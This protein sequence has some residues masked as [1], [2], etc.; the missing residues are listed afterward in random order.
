M[1]NAKTT[2]VDSEIAVRPKYYEVY[3][4]EIANGNRAWV[5]AGLMSLVALVSL[6]F[7]II[8]RIQVLVGVYEEM[9]GIDVP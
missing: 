9:V 1:E 2:E 4:A 7:A 6:A 8:V 5:L 3:G